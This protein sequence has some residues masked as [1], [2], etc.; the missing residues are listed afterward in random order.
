MNAID[1][2]KRIE[3]L[4]SSNMRD[5][6]ASLPKQVEEGIVLGEGVDLTVNREIRSVV[7]SGMG[8]SA[9]GGELLLAVFRDELR[10][11]FY[12]NREYSLPNYVD[13]K[14]LLFIVSYSGET[15]E[16]LSA[17][18]DGKKRKPLLI[19]ITSGGRLEEVFENHGTPW[20]H[21]PGGSPPRCALGYLSI[22]ILII[23]ERLGLVKSKKEDLYE[24]I[25]LLSSLRDRFKPSVPL[26]KN[27]AK[28]IASRIHHRFPLLYADS[29]YYEGVVHRWETQLNENAKVFAHTDLFPEMNHNEVMGWD[30]LKGE[31]EN[32]LEPIAIMLKDRDLPRNSHQRF[33]LTLEMLKNL[34]IELLEVESE[35][36][37]LLSRIFSAVYLGDYVSFYLAML[38][39]VDPTPIPRIREFKSRLKEFNHQGTKDTKDTKG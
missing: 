10:I 26:E 23:L 38:R 14:T 21:I 20:I 37:R 18:E 17:F 35:G 25:Q 2:M 16:T 15:E 32:S 29:L 8:G 5:L 27:P 3:E 4:D 30:Y 22:P 24:L 31:S 13:E 6:L 34:K 9:I 19:G 36:E 12:V 33:T 7:L 11:P 1:D 39:G 28:G